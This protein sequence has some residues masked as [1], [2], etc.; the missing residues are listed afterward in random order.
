MKLTTPIV[1][2][3]TEQNVVGAR[4]DRSLGRLNV[5]VAMVSKQGSV[6]FQA[7]LTIAQS[8]KVQKTDA[9]GVVTESIEGG[10]CQRIV[11]NDKPQGPWDAFKIDTFVSEHAFT[12]AR[13]ASKLDDD[14]AALEAAGVADGWLLPGA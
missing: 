10:V 12:N 9:E 4:F 2:E 6:I 13:A 14:M 11:V 1:L 3:V 5:A 7:D 8:L